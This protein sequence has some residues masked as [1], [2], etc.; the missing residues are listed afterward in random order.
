M[1]SQ[2]KGALVGI[3][4]VL[5]FSLV[6]GLA[7]QQD[8]TSGRVYGPTATFT[9]GTFT[10]LTQGGFNVLTTASPQAASSPLR[11]QTFV[12]ANGTSTTFGVLGEAV[13]TGSTGGGTGANAASST[14]M[15]SVGVTASVGNVASFNGTLNYAVAGSPTVSIMVKYGRTNNSR[16]WFGFTDQSAATMGASDLLHRVPEEL[17]CENTFF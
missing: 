1:R 13:T 3:A 7:A 2:L 12:T 6:G 15:Q 10:N 17:T 11:F 16:Y 8:T 5:F 4:A 14:A 9:T